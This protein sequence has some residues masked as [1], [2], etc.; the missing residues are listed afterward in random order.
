MSNL[1]RFFK[2]QICN[3]SYYVTKKERA[4]K[5]FQLK[6]KKQRQ[7]KN[8]RFRASVPN[9]AREKILVYGLSSAWMDKNVH[10]WC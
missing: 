3:I 1:K 10:A 2:L 6:K 4:G 5:K 7:K 8:L 9:L